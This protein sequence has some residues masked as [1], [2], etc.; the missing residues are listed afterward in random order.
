[1]KHECEK[2]PTGGW[3]LENQP[4]ATELWK[5]FSNTSYTAYVYRKTPTRPT[6][7]CDGSTCFVILS[8][9]IS[10]FFFS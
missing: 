8:N 10:L 3:L 9:V 7:T 2:R 1:M 5:S 6:V 4:E